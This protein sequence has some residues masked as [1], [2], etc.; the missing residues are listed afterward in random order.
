MD[1]MAKIQIKDMIAL[2]VLFLAAFWLWTLPLQNNPLPFGEH[3]GAYIFSYGDHMTYTGRS[4]D[5]VGD[6]PLS[7]LFWYS[8]YNSAL[9]PTT[10]EYPPPYLM[11]YAFAQVFGGERIVPPYLFIAITSFLSIFS[12]YLLIR[13]L[14]GFE[15]AILT[16]MGIMF[17]FRAISLYLWGQRHN[18][19]AFVYIPIAMYALYK[20]LKSFYDNNEKIVY[21]YLFVL[22]FLCTFLIHFGAT[23]FLVPYLI[24]LIS[25]MA[26]KYKK[27]PLSRKI[28]KQYA[29]IMAIV[30]IVIAPF[31][32]IYF[33]AEN[34]NIDL[35]LRDLG[36][37]LYWNKVPETSYSMNPQFSKYDVNYMG[38]WSLIPLFLGIAV[39]FIRRKDSDLV[40]LSALL[41][42]YI[43]FHLPAVGLVKFDS[44]RVGRFLAV[45]TYF[46]YALMAIGLTSLPSFFPIPKLWKK[47]VK[48][49]L[50]IL[51][52]F[53]VIKIEG[54][55]AYDS[56]NGAYPSISRI[57]PAQ[58]ELTEWIQENVPEVSAIH[59]MGTLSYAKKAYIQV[60][61]RRAGLRSDEK[62][63]ERELRAKDRIKPNFII[64]EEFVSGN[65]LYIPMNYIVFD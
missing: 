63:E 59:F 50:V 1:N 56:L 14:Y 20:Y 48:Y 22:M 61:S 62:P 39:L 32:L 24:I 16:S 25:L 64:P 43:I 28:I 58:Y 2:T 21:L 44:Y 51:F 46:F 26:V 5:I 29:I 3:D 37:F 8:G 35:G 57:T 42:L 17:S 55:D 27:L 65:D 15:V 6:S 7:I 53:L 30:L 12:M 19:F 10:L 54:G 45:E 38:R 47:Y 13:K 18:L 36:S 33:G 41:T 23:I 52:L 34:T 60:L 11:D 9:G 4:S 49:I 40:I 31:Y